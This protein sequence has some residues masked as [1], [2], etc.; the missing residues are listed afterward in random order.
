MFCPHV[1]GRPSALPRP[2]NIRFIDL[3]L[4][5]QPLAVGSNLGAP[6]LVQNRPGGLVAT[7]T[8]LPLKLKCREPCPYLVSVSVQTNGSLLSHLGYQ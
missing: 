6:E 7:N 5:L 2:A 1:A 3:D 4:L 8:Q